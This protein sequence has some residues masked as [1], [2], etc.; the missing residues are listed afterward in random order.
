MQEIAIRS[1]ELLDCRGVARI[2][3]LLD[4]KTETL[5]INEINTLPGSISFYLWEPMGINFSALVDKLIQLAFEAHQER[6]RTTYS[7]DSP[8]LARM[9][10]AG[11][12]TTDGPTAA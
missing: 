10:A 3:F 9:G 4:A 12:K 5:Y 6:Q 8:L 2:D 11:S 7:V 1:F